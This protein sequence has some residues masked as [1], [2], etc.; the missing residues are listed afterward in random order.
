MVWSRLS[1]GGW[2]GG[3]GRLP[4]FALLLLWLLCSIMTKQPLVAAAAVVTMLLLLMMKEEE[5]EEALVVSLR[6][7]SQSKCTLQRVLII[8]R[9]DFIKR[10]FVLILS[11]V[12]R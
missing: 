11:H 4:L 3:V 7:S 1:W 9:G 5:E 10:S 2:W 6:E 12:N 8:A